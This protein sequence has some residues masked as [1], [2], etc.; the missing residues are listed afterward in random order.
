MWQKK[1]NITSLKLSQQSN[2]QQTKGRRERNLASQGSPL[3]L[4]IARGG[5]KTLACE[6]EVVGSMPTV[7]KQFFS[8]SGVNT[9][10]VTSAKNQASEFNTT[11]STRYQS[12]KRF[13]KINFRPTVYFQLKYLREHTSTKI[14]GNIAII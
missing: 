1:P 12:L 14:Q 5:I 11:S 13:Y 7:V 4:R 9:L 10:R 3:Y 8:S 6:V 2:D